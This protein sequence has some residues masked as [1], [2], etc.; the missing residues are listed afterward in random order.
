MRSYPKCIPPFLLAPPSTLPLKP[1]N[2]LAAFR[3]TA[4]RHFTRPEDRAALEHVGSLLLESALEQAHLWPPYEGTETINSVAA[5]CR[6]LEHSCRFLRSV[7]DARQQAALLPAEHTLADA[8]A[9]NAQLLQTV[10]DQLRRA[11]QEC[12]A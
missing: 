9:R 8:A 5:V 4:L 7:A 2:E 3:E 11:H 1:W 10:I 6:D 12:L